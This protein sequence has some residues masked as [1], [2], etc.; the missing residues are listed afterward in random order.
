MSNKY[1]L[2]IVLKKVGKQLLVLL[3]VFL[4]AV[5]L[6]LYSASWKQSNNYYDNGDDKQYPYDGAKVEED[7]AKKP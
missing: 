4:V 7:K 3:A 2:L 6:T 1:D 5:W